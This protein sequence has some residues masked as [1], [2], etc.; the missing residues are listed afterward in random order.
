[1]KT[2][3][4]SLLAI[5]LM[6][7]SS[8]AAVVISEIDLLNNKIELVNNGLAAVDVTG[9]FFCNRFNGSPF[10]PA[11]TLGLVDVAN[12]SANSLSIAPGAYLTFAMTAAFIP[13]ASGEIGLY[14]N[15]SNFGASANIVDYVGWGAN[16]TR[17]SVA[18][19]A[20][21]WGDGTFVNVTAITA[22]Q[23]IQL[24]Q[25]LAGNSVADY[26][27]AASTIGFNQ[28]PEPTTATLAGLALLALA[29]RQRN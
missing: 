17:D 27:L 13:D 12:S 14:I 24:K 21:I 22:G 6:S 9:F 29:R 16:G 28:V 19:A 25:G 15:G 11:I 2:P 5:S 20:G 3:F 8:E 7:S 1:M 26:Q 23:T 10:Y 4:L 18:A